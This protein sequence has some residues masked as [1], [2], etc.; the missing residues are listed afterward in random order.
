MT[1]YST[2]LG[3]LTQWTTGISNDQTLME[4]THDEYSDM[5]LFPGTCNS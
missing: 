5:L 2:L 4:Y 1:V 3:V